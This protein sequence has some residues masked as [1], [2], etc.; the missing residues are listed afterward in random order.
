MNCSHLLETQAFLDGETSGAA[1][2]AAE[3]HIAG[4][5]ECRAFAADAGA[6]ADGM[7]Q[8]T[9]ARAPEA[10]RAR[11]Q[12]ALARE[13]APG[14]GFWNQSFWTGVFSGGLATGLAGAAALFVWLSSTT[15]T[16][17]SDLAQA[18]EK[19]LL[20]GQTIMVASSDHHTVKPWLAAHVAISPPTADFTAQGFPLTGGRR[21]VIAGVPAAVAVYARG[22]HKIDLF[23]WPDK[24]GALPA[25]AV[26]RGFHSQFWKSGDLDFAAISDI[27]AATFARFV[28]LAQNAR[29]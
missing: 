8:L 14:R 22:R 5:M 24:G 27:D 12:A 29:E 4:C 25:P 26:T 28:A 10:L 13:T 15:A 20:S 6:L 9:R 21:D 16:L 7:R 23:A 1:A 2:E 18:H 19:A 11:V 17:T 3:L